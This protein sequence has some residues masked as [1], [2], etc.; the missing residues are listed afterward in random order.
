MPPLVKKALRP[1][2]LGVVVND[3]DPLSIKIAEYYVN[4]RRIPEENLIHINIKHRGGNM[5]PKQFI[6]IHN[7]VKKQTPHHI[8]AYALTW[9]HPFRV[10]CMSITSA[11][12]TGYDPKYCAI[13]TIGKSC[14]ITP[15]S[16]Y[17]SSNSEA[18][19]DDLKIR[20]TMMIA[21]EGFE[22]AKRLIVRGIR[23]DGSFPRGTAYLLKTKDRN[24]SVRAR[25]FP[26][27][28]QLFS[29][30]I[31]LS[32]LQQDEIIGRDDVMFYITGKSRV[33][34]INSLKFLPG[35]V[36]DHLTSG[37][38]HMPSGKKDRW[39][40]SA[41]RWLE[42]GATGSYG[43]V[44]EPCNY[45]TKFPRPDILLNYYLQ[46]E[47][48]IEAYWKSVAWPSEGLFIGEPLAAPY[49]L[50]WSDKSDIKESSYAQ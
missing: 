26:Q 9:M 25:F 34:Q 17:F 31:A 18:P 29:D 33:K 23:S 22:E 1:E 15:K 48:L 39:Q 35:A 12:A 32:I 28:K 50:R 45:V 13:K 10:G 41:L 37:G 38:G 44:V 3:A 21:A 24:R 6:S 27:V 20:P 5:P 49:S 16:P 47:T 36:A 2:Q 14:G 4:A 11:F 43:T 40:M 19:F 42:A 7:Q 46:G 30:K 8:Q